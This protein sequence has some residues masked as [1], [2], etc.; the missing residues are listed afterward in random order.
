MANYQYMMSADDVARELN[1]SKSH[2][3]KLVKSMNEEL[4][5][6]GYITMAGRIPRAYWAKKNVWLRIISRIGK[7]SSMAYKEKTLRNG[8]PNGLKQMPGVK[9][10]SEEKEVLRQSERLLSMSDRRN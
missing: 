6:Q 7:E 4:A 1:C 3:Y 2:A 9:R 10:K 5:S 8:Q